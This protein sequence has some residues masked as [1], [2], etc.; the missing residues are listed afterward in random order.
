MGFVNSLVLAFEC[1]FSFKPLVSHSFLNTETVQK[2]LNTR[3]DTIRN[4]YMLWL[5][6]EP[7]VY[8]KID[9]ADSKN[10]FNAFISIP[11]LKK[12]ISYVCK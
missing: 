2:Y 3:Y 12:L 6:V 11:D 8:H 1:L 10:I 9:T 4:Y 7:E 5:K